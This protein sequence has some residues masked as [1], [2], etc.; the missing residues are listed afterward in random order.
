MN[1]LFDIFSTFKTDSI[2]EK[3]ITNDNICDVCEESNLIY[4]DGAYY[5]SKCGIFKNKALS[6]DIE[7]YYG[8]FDN[9]STNPERLGMPTNILLPE[10]SLGSLISTKS[11]NSFKKMIQ[12]NI[13]N[14]MPYKER[15]QLKVFTD[16][17][18]KSKSNGIP[19]II[20][21]QAKA[22][23]KIIS[24]KSIH[25]GSNRSGLIAACMYMAC[26]KENVPRSTKEIAAIFEINIQDMTKGCKKFKEIFRLNNIEIVKINSSNPLDYIERFCSNLRLSKDIKYVCEF[27]AIKALTLKENI[28][29]DNT[30][31]S[32]AA[33]TIFL[34]TN[35]L[36]YCITKKVVAGACKIS[37]VTISEC[38]KKLNKYKKNFAE[39]FIEENNI[40]V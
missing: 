16:I 3:K 22:Y 21:E 33:G 10:S 30:S 37:E 25:R 4:E 38:Y 13:W 35:L 40:M 23:Y 32:I 8:D 36:N 12:Y 20:I 17:A 24:E 14:S 15:S 18:N 6:Q 5:C 27:V 28:V 26:Q 1:D 31:P 39:K 11:S 34:V 2:E 29:E 9:K 7:R 19:T